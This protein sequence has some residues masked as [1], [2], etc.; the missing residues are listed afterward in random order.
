M[1]QVS[2]PLG[3]FRAGSGQVDITPRAG[4]QLFGSVGERR[5]VQLVADP[6]Y[7]KAVCFE[8][9]S[10]KI[11]FV[12]LDVTIVTQEYTDQIRQATTQRFGIHPDAIMVHA[13]QTHSAP[14]LGNDIMVDDDFQQLPADYHWIRGG[15]KGYNADTVERTLEAVRLADESLEPAQIAVG[16]GIEGRL[17]FNRRGVKQDGSVTMPGRC[18]ER[19]LGPTWIRYLEGPIDPELGVMCVRSDTLSMIAMLLHYTCHPVHVFPKL[20]VS[21]DWPG[22]WAEEL[23]GAHGQDCVPLV[24]NGACGNINPWP[25]YDPDYVEDHRY[26]GQKLAETTEK[27]VETLT[28]RDVDVLDWRVKHIKIPIRDV[29][30]DDLAAAR[31]FLAEYPEPLWMDGSNRQIDRRWMR[32]AGLLSIYLMKQREEEFT[33]EIQV[34]RVGDTAFVGLPGEPFVEGQLCIKMAS[35]IYPTYVAHCT[36]QYVGYLP[37]REAVGRGGHEATTSYWAKLVPDALDR[38][39]DEAIAMLD[40]IF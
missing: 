24:L 5:P 4:I 20:V 19:P 2:A 27:V 10:R 14:A 36:T 6:L 16:S 12:S 3:R 17:A 22:A 37:T 35:P 21:A 30:P 32:A 8:L 7:A 1:T 25:P 15:D 29:D 39:V 18:W 40:E 13:T 23:R 9:N 26:M 38:V 33:Y 28:F 11:C 31:Q 34:L